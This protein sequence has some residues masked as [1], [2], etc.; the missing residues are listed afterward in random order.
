LPANVYDSMFGNAESSVGVTPAGYIGDYI[1]GDVV[2]FFWHTL[3]TPSTNGTIKIYRNDSSSEITMPTGISDD[4]NFD[5][6]SGV[7]LCGV[8]LSANNFYAKEKDFTVVLDGA[9]INNKTVNVVLA[10]FSI[11][12]R[13]A[14]RAFV[15]DG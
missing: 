15:R 11:E 8:D 13:Y 3:I 4:R 10:T 9:I 12:N 1:Q 7:N 6:M 5:S 14:G 2:Y